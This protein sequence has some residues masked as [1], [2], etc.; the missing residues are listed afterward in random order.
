MTRTSWEKGVAPDQPWS[1]QAD[2]TW[3]TVCLIALLTGT[4]FLF[5][6]GLDTNGWANPYYSAAAQAG[7]VDWKAFLFGSIDAGNAITIDKPPLSIWVMSLVSE[8][9]RLSSWSILVPQALMGVA[10]TWLIYATIRRSHPR[11]PGALRR[12]GV[13]DHPRCRADVAFQQSGT[14]DGIACSGGAVYCI[15]R[16]LEDNY[17]RWYILRGAA[18]GLGFMAKQLQ[19]F[20]VVPALVV[21]VIL[22]GAGSLASR[23]RR[24]F[25]SPWS[26]SYMRRRVDC[27]R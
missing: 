11:R 23:I 21:T 14:S 10:T 17:W 4:A 15:V 12:L 2:R 26:A 18:L 27:I 5:I 9:V 25:G 1:G 16:G 3:E 6:W 7:S 22:V 24:L 8:G 13:R 20:L 19:A